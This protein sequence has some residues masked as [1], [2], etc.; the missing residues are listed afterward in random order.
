MI[1]ALIFFNIIAWVWALAMKFNDLKHLNCDIKKIWGEIKEIR[2]EQ[3]EQG[4]NISALES[5]RETQE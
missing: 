3:V 1:Y 4:K 2:A 5:W